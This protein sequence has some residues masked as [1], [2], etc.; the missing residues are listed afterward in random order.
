MSRLLC[1][2]GN[3]IRDQTDSLPYKASLLPDIDQIPFFD[4][5]ISETQ[6]YVEAA[7]KESVD[8]WLLDNGYGAEYVELKLPHG[9]ILHDHI[10]TQYLDR[11]RD[12]Y[13]CTNCG[14][15]HIETSQPNIFASFSPDD[16]AGQGLFE[17]G[18]L[19]RSL[20]DGER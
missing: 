10:H 14:R 4:W 7:R 1:V 11:K 16:N 6:S 12:L 17:Q 5:L 20:A 9:H 15:V 19:Q 3:L 2:C 13:Q 18:I 8:G